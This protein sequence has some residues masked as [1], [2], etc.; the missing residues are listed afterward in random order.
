MP[1]LVRCHSVPE[2]LDS[3]TISLMESLTTILRKCFCS[4]HSLSI[5]FMSGL[6]A[7]CGQLLSCMNFI[8]NLTTKKLFVPFQT[9]FFLNVFVCG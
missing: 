2:N 9:N 3:A 5:G 1:T 6:S 4:C 8:L 7:V